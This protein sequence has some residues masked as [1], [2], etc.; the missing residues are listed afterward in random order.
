MSRRNRSLDAAAALLLAIAV[1]G[2]LAA[3][4]APAPSPTPPAAP[5]PAMGAVPV[6]IAGIR[7][8][9]PDQVLLLLADDGE[10]RAVPIAVGRDQGIAI[11]LG[12]MK[13]EATRPLTHDLLAT[14][15]GVVGAVI[16]KITVT[17]LKDD[18]YFA[19]IALRAGGRLHPIDARP[20]DAIALAVRLNAPMYSVS[21]LLK[22]I[23]GPESGEPALHADARLGLTVQELDSA[24][25]ESLGASDVE[26]V[27]VASVAKGGRAE[28]A[29]VRRGDIVQALD[30]R[31]IPGLPAYLEAA[32]K[33]VKTLT[34]WRD[35]RT[36][37]LEKLTP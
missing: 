25:A 35:G 13:A 2:A 34:I 29:G 28:R 3:R 20:S 32:G 18:V 31:P 7:P 17:D 36:T 22:P 23:G 5:G 24:L 4:P 10:R 1:L 37:T 19:E 8:T 11:Y 16:E 6:H 12:K 14:I 27:L 26:G 33:E 9:G 15:L 21:S 30:G